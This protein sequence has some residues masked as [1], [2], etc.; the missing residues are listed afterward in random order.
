MGHNVSIATMPV[1]TAK[2]G[3][4]MA[5]WIRQGG[6]TPTVIEIITADETVPR[7]AD[8]DLGVSLTP[9]SV[10]LKKLLLE[11]THRQ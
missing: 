10:T 3:A 11:N 4:A 9:L 1:W 6:M 2:L 7:N 5:S 8:V